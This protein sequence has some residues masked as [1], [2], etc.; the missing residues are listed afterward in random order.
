MFPA[1]FEYLAPTSLQEAIALLGKNPG[2]AK[3]LAGGH[4][5]I[6]LMKLRLAAP[7]Y[8]IDI[9]RIDGLAYIREEADTL[10]I[11]PM[12][13][14][15]SI[16]TSEIVRRLVPLLAETAA[17]I[18]DVQVR[19]R[20]TIGGSLAHA[21]P[22]GDFPAAILALEAQIKAIGPSG[23][24]TIKA[25]D[26]FVDLLTTALASDEILSEIRVPIPRGRVG[27]SYQKFD[28]PASHYA[29]AGVAALIALGP[30]DTIQ[31]ARV[32]ITGVGP[33]AYRATSVER[34]LEGRTAS[35]ETIASAAQTAADGVDVAGDIHAS[36]EY[37][38]HL[39]RVYARRAVQ[40]AV[41]RARGR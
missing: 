18:G 20:G 19:N 32:G 39:A 4:S 38:A 7:R 8:L 6:P 10:A 11:G 1:S 40:Q 37:R 9:G 36:S 13:T 16:E 17:H 28:N 30:D 35:D 3:I 15:H 29:I 26:F 5:L 21:D 31:K 27:T 23:E 12:T 14:H 41:E 25:E 34:A 33:K 24:R 22:A 2:E